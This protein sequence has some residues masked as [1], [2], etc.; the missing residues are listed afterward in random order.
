[1]VD[2]VVSSVRN[3]RGGWEEIRT[4]KIMHRSAA[5]VEHEMLFHA[6][7]H[8]GYGNL[9]K[10]SGN[11]IRTTFNRVSTKTAVQEYHHAS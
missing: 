10:I 1:L 2:V 8:L 9:K 3:V 7:N 11:N 5:S 4:E 6:S